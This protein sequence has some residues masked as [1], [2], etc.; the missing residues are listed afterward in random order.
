MSNAETGVCPVSVFAE[1]AY[2]NDLTSSTRR[3]VQLA[4]EV[5]AAQQLRAFPDKRQRRLRPAA[6]S[7]RHDAGREFALRSGGGTVN[8]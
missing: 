8:Y 5:W 1:V 3:V 6:L 2:R 4:D 7:G